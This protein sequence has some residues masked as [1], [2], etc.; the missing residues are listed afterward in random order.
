MLSY[1]LICI[2]VKKVDSSTVSFNN[3]NIEEKIGS[4]AFDIASGNVAKSNLPEDLTSPYLQ[5]QLNKQSCSIWSFDKYTVA[6]KAEEV[7]VEKRQTH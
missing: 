6:K 3:S 1:N 4:G 7:H 2:Q 5:L